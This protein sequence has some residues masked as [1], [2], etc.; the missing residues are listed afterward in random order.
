MQ[1]PG[2]TNTWPP[3]YGEEA[4][5][6]TDQ[7]HICRIIIPYFSSLVQRRWE[8]ANGYFE[9]CG[10]GMIR[11][12]LMSVVYGLEVETHPYRAFLLPYRQW[13]GIGWDFFVIIFSP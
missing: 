10:V 4:P 3:V 11:A 1:E 9:L 13:F 8:L 12:R 7:P 6:T 5:Y 2:G